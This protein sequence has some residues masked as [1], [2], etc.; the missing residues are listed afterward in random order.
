MASHTESGILDL[1]S[2]ADLAREL[3][4]HGENAFRKKYPHPFLVLLND[5][6]VVMGRDSHRTIETLSDHL[7]DQEI[8]DPI[9]TAVA[10]VKSS[11]N[12]YTSKITLGRADYSDIRFRSSKLS[13]LHS[14]F[15]SAEGENVWQ[16]IDLGSVNGTWVNRVRLDKK[17]PRLLTNGD[18]IGFWRYEFEFMNLDSFIRFLRERGQNAPVRAGH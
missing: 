8:H 9:S 7:L 14:A 16:V 6:M 12:E 3:E 4:Q 5:P 1:L 2:L 17:K 13:R 18:K 15:E 11:R 10:V